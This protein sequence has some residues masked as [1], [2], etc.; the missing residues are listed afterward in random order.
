[1]FELNDGFARGVGKLFDG[2]GEFA[3]GARRQLRAF[4]ADRGQRGVE[5]FQLAAM[6]E[7]ALFDAVVERVELG[8]RAAHRLAGGQ[9]VGRQAVA[10][11]A[12]LVDR[13]AHGEHAGGQCF[14][15]TLAAGERGGQI[16]A[17]VVGAG[18]NQFE[19]AHARFGQAGDIGLGAAQ[20][21]PPVVQTLGQR[22]EAGGQ[23]RFGRAAV[24]GHFGEAA[25]DLRKPGDH[26]LALRGERGGA[27][28]LL[29]L[30]DCDILV[31]PGDPFVD[32]RDRGGFLLVGLLALALH[33]ARE[34]RVALGEAL[35]EMAGFLGQCREARACGVGGGAIGV[36]ERGEG[37][38]QFGLDGLGLLAP[39]G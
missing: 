12:G 32:Q 3:L 6:R 24:L 33:L 31:E 37:A 21:Q 29:L 28:A 14:E 25:A 23:R 10:A 11:R 19:Q 9:D 5:L 13:V 8:H 15:P 20:L 39:G 16:L 22:R 35:V 30:A 17:A 26:R 7:P 27:C 4:G 38:V 1:M 18:A 2:A 34:E 36:V